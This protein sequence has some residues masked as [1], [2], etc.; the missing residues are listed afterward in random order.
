[1]GRSTQR[2]LQDANRALANII[3]EFKHIGWLS[4]R[5]NNE[6]VSFKFPSKPWPHNLFHEYSVSTSSINRLSSKND[7]D[8][9]YNPTA[10]KF[11]FG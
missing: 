1:M 2:A 5:D 9:T 10:K 8:K 7:G 11:C 3:G 4:R 6:S